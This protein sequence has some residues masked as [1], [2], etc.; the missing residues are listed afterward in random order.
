MFGPA[1]AAVTP[2][3]PKPGYDKEGKRIVGEKAISPRKEGSG[4]G[5]RAW[6]DNTTFTVGINNIWDA[7]A[8]LAVDNVQGNYDNGNA[9]AIGRYFWVSVEKKF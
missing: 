6:L 1:A 4:R 2:E 3:M 5:L 8:P 9:N 7:H